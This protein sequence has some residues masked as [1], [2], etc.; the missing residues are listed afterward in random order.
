MVER[1]VKKMRRK[2]KSLAMLLLGVLIFSVNVWAEDA[3]VPDDPFYT[4]HA[5]ACVPNGRT[6]QANGP[7]NQVILYESPASAKVMNTLENGEVTP[8][9]YTYTNEQGIEWGFCEVDG[10]MGWLPMPYMVLMYDYISFEED[11]A[12]QII[13]ERKQMIHMSSNLP[14]DREMQMEFMN[15]SRQ[16]K[17]WKYPGSTERYIIKANESSTSSPEYKKVFVDEEGRRWGFITYYSGEHLNR[18]IC[19]NS[20]KELLADVEEL[21]PNG[22]PIRDTRVIEAYEGEEIFPD[23]YEQ[24]QHMQKMRTLRLQ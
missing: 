6:Y 18:W 15:S 4:E 23:D 3:W 2:V 5:D 12:D 16:I 14:E 11:Y 22:A 8:I 21:Y 13:E 9:D 24:V 10:I 7:N 1:C 19:I 20:V 17:F